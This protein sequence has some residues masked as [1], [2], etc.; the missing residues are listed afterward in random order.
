M[1]AKFYQT[2]PLHFECTG[3]GDCC[4]GGGEYQVFVTAMEAEAI[5]S[6]LGL[7]RAW[8][9]RRY[10]GRYNGER[11]LAAN[12]DACVFLRR[13]RT[14]RVY[15]VRPVQC[16]TYPY[17]PELL[18]SERA[19]RREARRCQGIGRGPVISQATIEAHLRL[20]VGTGDK[21]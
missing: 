8:F 13:D 21:P 1:S 15:A 9:R 14:C 17:W 11:V 16:R 7:S 20:L 4:L 6:F 18:D 10:L 2:T 19:W 12:G 3:C 5:R